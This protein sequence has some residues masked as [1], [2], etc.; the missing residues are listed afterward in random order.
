MKE[1]KVKFV[2]KLR[3]TPTVESFRFEK[4]DGLESVPGQFL[5]LIFDERDRQNH[6][7][8]KYLSFSSSPMREYI[9]VTKRL[10][11]SEFSEKLRELKPT[12][13][14]LIRAP[15]GDCV[16][17]KETERIGFLIGGIGITPVISMLE[18]IV[19]KNLD[20]DVSLFYSNR[21]EEEIAFKNELK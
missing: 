7:L 20:I 21:S 1:F 3:R 16:L 6:N 4:P 19:E 10:S 9:E 13:E 15:L 5:Q 17:D 12:D 14:V 18:Y 8:N 11:H 2:D